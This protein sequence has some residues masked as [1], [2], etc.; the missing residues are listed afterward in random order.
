[1][2]SQS[3][4]A[5]VGGVA[6]CGQNATYL[7][8][9]ERVTRGVLLAGL[10]EEIPGSTRWLPVEF[11]LAVVQLIVLPFFTVVV[12]LIV[13]SSSS[14]SPAPPD[15]EDGPLERRDPDADRADLVAARAAASFFRSS[16][17]VHGERLFRL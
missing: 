5:Q 8:S 16:A 15:A 6:A 17:C 7:A 10:L 14:T 1:M 2:L 13:G 12:V 11:T 3:V 9:G 4:L